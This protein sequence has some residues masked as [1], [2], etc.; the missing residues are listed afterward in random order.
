MIMTRIFTVLLAGFFLFASFSVADE[1]GGKIKVLTFNTWGI[2]K[3][4]QR[5]TRFEAIG[6][7]IA[8]LDPDIVAIQEAFT[9]RHRSLLKKSLEKN[10]YKI[11]GW[12][13]FH[14]A[15]GSGILFVSKYP[16]EKIVWKPYVVAGA[17]NDIEWLGG[18]GIACVKIKTP[19][20]PLDFFETH[21]IARMTEIFDAQGNFMPG[22]YNEVDRHIHMF[23]IDRIVRDNRTSGGRSMIM[24]G[25]FN[26]SPQMPEYKLLMA[27]TGFENIID[28]LHPGE[29][30]ST[31]SAQNPFAAYESSR[32]D[33]IFFK[34][35]RGDA[36]F[37]LKPILSRVEMYEKFKSPESGE[38]INYSDHYG[39]YAEFEVVSDP[40]SGKISPDGLGARQPADIKTVNLEGYANGVLTLTRDNVDSW[41][42]F[43]LKEYREAYNRKNRNN[44]LLI[45]L[46]EIIT[47]SQS[48]LPVEITLRPQHRPLMEQTLK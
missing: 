4:Q 26:V 24:A 25:D 18:K 15:Y 17:W 7:K 11:G 32:I 34:N 46:G 6:K 36:G 48:T 40:A 37:W 13:Y 3:A 20:G 44:Q 9:S 10:G 12:K 42:D 43:S 45:P 14:R 35:Y 5:S 2:V 23:Q 27:L 22:D 47:Q 1:G 16:I 33:H 28:L 30:P 39:V 21:A 31:Y 29:N 41:L 8:Q 38:M 19:Y